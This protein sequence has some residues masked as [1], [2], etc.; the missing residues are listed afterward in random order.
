MEKSAGQ[1]VVSLAGISD[2]AAENLGSA[3]S[4][5]KVMVRLHDLTAEIVPEVAR[6][7]LPEKMDN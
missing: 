6:Y 2:V 7:Q 4:L 3:Q 5:E 1:V